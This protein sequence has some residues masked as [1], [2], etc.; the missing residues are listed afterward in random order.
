MNAAS[1]LDAGEYGLYAL[2]DSLIA[3]KALS[4]SGSA[5]DMLGYSVASAG[6]INGDGEH[7][8]IVGA[9]DISVSGYTGDGGYIQVLYAG[10][11]GKQVDTDGDFVADTLDNCIDDPNTDQSDADADGI[12]D[13]CDPVDNPASTTGGS[14]NTGGGGGGQ[15]GLYVLMLLCMMVMGQAARRRWSCRIYRQ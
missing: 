13:V 11:A 8:Y 5:H 15:L 12:G 7:D 14:D 1:E 6:D 2:D 9:P 3:I 4:D 10:L